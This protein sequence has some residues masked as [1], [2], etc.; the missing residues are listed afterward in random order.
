M[1]AKF[2]IGITWYSDHHD[3]L[4]SKLKQLDVSNT[5]GEMR[6]KPDKTT[7]LVIPVHALENLQSSALRKQVH[8]SRI[9]QMSL[10]TNTM[11]TVYCQQHQ[12]RE[13]WQ[14]ERRETAVLKLVISPQKEGGQIYLNGVAFFTSQRYSITIAKDLLEH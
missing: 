2:L 11:C 13:Q 8:R 9:F 12:T 1:P 10:L 14:S 5:C 7:T 3:I 4:H 6:I